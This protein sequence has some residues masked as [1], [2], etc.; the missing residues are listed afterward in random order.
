MRGEKTHFVTTTGGETLKFEIEKVVL[1]PV[2][3]PV[4][5]ETNIELPLEVVSTAGVEPAR[6][7]DTEV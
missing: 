4:I 3:L 2:I 5:R 7:E 6:L 1:I